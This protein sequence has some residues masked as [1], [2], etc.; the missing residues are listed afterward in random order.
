MRINMNSAVLVLLMAV[1]ALSQEST[2]FSVSELAQRTLHRRAVEAAIWGMPLVN[3]DSMRQAYV[4]AGA[5]YND[6]IFWSNPNTWMNQTTTPNHS[7]SYIMA[8]WNLKDGPL[9]VE[10]P[11]AQEQALYGTLINSWNEPQMNVGATGLD[12]GA[13]AKYLLLP[14]GYKEQPPEGY[15]AVPY[16]TYNGYFL[17]RVILRDQSD[18]EKQAGLKFAHTVKV[19]PLSKAAAPEPNKFIDVATKPFEAAP[20]FDA[21]FYTSLA[22]MVEQEPVQ[23]RDL[24][25]MGLVRT[26]NIGKELKFA[27]DAKT[28]EVLD[29][30]AEEA[31]QFMMEGFLTAGDLIWPKSSETWHYI[32]DLK[33]ARGSKL[34]F[35]EPGKDLR[36]DDR[37]YAWFAMFGPPVPPPPQLYIKAVQT[38]DGSRLTGG[39]TYRLRVPPNV[40]AKNFWAVD[41]YDATTGTFIR[42]S[43]VVGIDSYNEKLKKNDDGT[44][45]IY[46]APKAPAGEE[47]NWVLTRD[48][49]PFF[50]MFRFYGPE[51]RAVDGSW[52]L[53]EIEKVN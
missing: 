23:E 28:K 8:F 40:P 18:A 17:L 3:V 31:H 33:L 14:P 30:A 15:V 43:P 5:K 39:N 25:M 44:V 2:K 19:Y 20:V 1:P 42:E 26:L 13:G 34:T 53:N 36:Y 12:K 45:D 37:G 52:V 29:A 22:R 16:T 32:L 46:F 21:S 38:K 27:P 7:T 4:R 6:V 49:K 11:K 48:G 35:I 50:L 51:P 47:N 24:T 41:V 10:I 9:V